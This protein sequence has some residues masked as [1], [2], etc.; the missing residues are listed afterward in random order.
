MSHP[1]K[2]TSSCYL[3][4]YRFL[5]LA[6]KNKKLFRVRKQLKK[7]FFMIGCM[8]HPEKFTS[9]CYFGNNRSLGLDFEEKRCL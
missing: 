4:T 8:S 7:I 3:E 6:Y 5:I 1:E 9:P 2:A